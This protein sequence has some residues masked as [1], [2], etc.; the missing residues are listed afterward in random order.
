MGSISYLGIFLDKIVDSDVDAENERDDN[1][2]NKD[3]DSLLIDEII[4]SG[5][6]N[7]NENEN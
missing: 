5:A 7:E 1:E 4:D 2:E 3:T 6:D